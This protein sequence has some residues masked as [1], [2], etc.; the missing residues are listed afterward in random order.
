MSESSDLG[1][2]GTGISAVA[3]RRGARTTSGRG[4]TTKPK[5][6]SPARATATRSPRKIGYSR[7]K[8]IDDFVR[9][10]CEA[11]PLQLVEM[12]RHGVAGTFLKDLAKHLKVPAVRMFDMLGVPKATAEKKSSA[13]EVITGSGGHAAIGMAKL[14]GIALDIVANST[15]KG[16]A[17]FDAAAWLGDWLGRPQPSLGGRAPG[18]FMDTPTGVEMVARLLGAVESGAYQ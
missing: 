15:A 17:E 8:S 5:P 3:R 6:A 2:S 12:E 10:V 14:L 4:K 9:Q 7:G 18:Q 16:A 1:K 11:T 13:G